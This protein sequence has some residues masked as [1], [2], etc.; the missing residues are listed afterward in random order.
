MNLLF[1]MCARAGSKGFKNKNIQNFL[2][3]PLPHFTLSA[4]DLFC[5]KNNDKYEH[6]SV[7]VNTDSMEFI[8]IVKGTSM[9]CIY[10]PRKSELA[11]DIVPK[12]DV[13]RDTFRESQKISGIDYN[14]T[15]DLDITSPLRRA[16]DIENASDTLMRDI[17]CDLVLS[18]AEARRNPFFNMVKE[19]N[20]YYKKVM[21]S[22][23][24]ARQQ[25]PEI[26]D[27]NGSIYAYSKS[28]MAR[29][30]NKPL[31]DGNVSII[32][33]LDTAVLDIDSKADFE[34]M[35]I[36]AKY[37]YSKNDEYNEVFRNISSLSR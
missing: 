27:I 23:Y 1:T 36:I 15:I 33:M 34:L 28:F 21:D 12:V 14:I 25:A 6:I 2:D 22:D 18:V 37:I 13:I 11:E 8:D 20:G 7:A 3:Y 10:I 17:N 31:L 4:I 32:Q 29:T 24:T 9:D 16:A 35:Q 5:N 19:D 30:D 26:Y